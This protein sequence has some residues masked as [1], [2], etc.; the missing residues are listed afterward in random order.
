M[1]QTS[2]KTTREQIWQGGEV[3]LLGIVQ[4]IYWNMYMHKSEAV[5]ENETHEIIVNFNK[6]GSTSFLF[7]NNERLIAHLQYGCVLPV[8]NDWQCSNLEMTLKHEYSW[9]FVRQLLTSTCLQRN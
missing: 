5:L 7:F 2:T 9:A 6:S 4:E 3:D 8:E 1:L